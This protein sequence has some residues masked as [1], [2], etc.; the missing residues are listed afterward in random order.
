MQGRHKF[1]RIYISGRS[2]RGNTRAGKCIECL[3]SRIDDESLE[4]CIPPVPADHLGVCV[5]RGLQ[6]VIPVKLICIL[7]GVGHRYNTPSALCNDSIQI[8]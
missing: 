4:V 5:R 8:R 2:A 7:Y 1:G 6:S 3:E